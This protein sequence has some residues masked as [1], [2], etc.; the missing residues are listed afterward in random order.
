MSKP[1]Y[2]ILQAICFKAQGDIG[3]LSC[4]TNKREIV[5]FLK[6]WLRDPASSYQIAHRNRIRA[7]ARNW[8]ALS[9]QDKAKWERVTKVLSLYINGYNLWVCMSMNLE[10][11]GALPTLNRQSHIILTLPPIE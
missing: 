10:A 8:Q 6:A 7:C 11:R 9:S 3:P 5:M 1:G 4:Y 2:F